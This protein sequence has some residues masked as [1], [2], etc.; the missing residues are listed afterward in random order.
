VV[1]VGVAVMTMKPDIFY[2][3]DVLFYPKDSSNRIRY[4]LISCDSNQVLSGSELT[5]LEVPL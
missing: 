2:P 5:I 4:F 3:V 1:C